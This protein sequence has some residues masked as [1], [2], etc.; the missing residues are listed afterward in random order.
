MAL[1]EE[2]LLLRVVREAVPEAAPEGAVAGAD[3][4]LQHVADDQAD[5]LDLGQL[6]RAPVV[7][8]GGALEDVGAALAGGARV[9]RGVEGARVEPEAV[10]GAAEEAALGGGE[11][12]ARGEVVFPFRERVDG[13]PFLGDAADF[14]ELVE[15]RGGGWRRAHQ[16]R[17]LAGVVGHQL[18]GVLEGAELGFGG[19]VEDWETLGGGEDF[20]EV[21]AC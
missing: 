11:E 17:G 4:V 2:L 7:Q 18:D 21:V 6:G 3:M 1:E 5:V 13:F 19:A 15:Q 12:P 20:S 8:E 10:D 9:G 16:V 14:E